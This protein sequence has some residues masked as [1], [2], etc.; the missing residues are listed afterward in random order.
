MWLAGGVALPWARRGGIATDWAG[1][2]SVLQCS[3]ALGPLDRGRGFI[4]AGKGLTCT[5]VRR[6]PG[7]AGLSGVGRE[8]ALGRGRGEDETGG[9]EDSRGLAAAC[10]RPDVLQEALQPHDLARR[11]GRRD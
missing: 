4:I 6:T 9:D 8:R 7:G 3:A 5:F 11:F 10:L 2:A 1:S